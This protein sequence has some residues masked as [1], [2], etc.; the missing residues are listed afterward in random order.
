LSEK[1]KAWEI[2]LYFHM[3]K[4]G[5]VGRFEFPNQIRV[6]K[7]SVYHFLNAPDD[8]ALFAAYRWAQIRSIG[9]DRCLSRAIATSTILAGPTEH[10]SFWQLVLRFLV[11]NKVAVAE[12]ISTINFI[13]EQKFRP[14][15]EV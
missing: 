7:S 6:S 10:G 5:S 9:G 12:A 13:D 2:D 3:A 11:R 8:C 15:S 4:G 1:P 14:A